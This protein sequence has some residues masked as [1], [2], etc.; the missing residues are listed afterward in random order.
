MKKL[1]ALLLA[2]CL[3]LP[4]ISCGKKEEA[5][6]EPEPTQAPA[7]L[8]KVAEAAKTVAAKEIKRLLEDAESAEDFKAVIDEMEGLFGEDEELTVNGETVTLR[9]MRET[10]EKLL[11]LEAAENAVTA[12]KP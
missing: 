4:L 2:L 1:L 3:A 8:D 12:L 9:Q 11:A 6:P 5:P 7:S 10:Y